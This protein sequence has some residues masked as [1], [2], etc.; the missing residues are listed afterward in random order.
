[1][2]NIEKERRKL[3]RSSVSLTAEV[4][5]RENSESF[6][7]EVT[8]V[9]NV[10]RVG[11]NFN[12]KRE[13][14]VGRLV[15]LSINMPEMFRRYDYGK[16]LYRVWGLVQH[17]RPISEADFDGYQI[18]VAFVGKLAPESYPEDPMKSYRVTGIDSD[19]F[20][21][22]G[23][24]KT[25]FVTREYLRFPCSLK[26]RIAQ[27]DPDGMGSQVEEKAIM[28]NVS[29]AGASVFSRL[30]LNSGDSVMFVCDEP[31][32]SSIAVVRNRQYREGDRSTLH[33]QFTENFPVKDLN[34]SFESA[35]AV[36]FDD[37]TAEADEIKEEK[38]SEAREPD[39]LDALEKPVRIE[40]DSDDEILEINGS[41][42]EG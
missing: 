35:E 33:L 3:S 23:E 38:E 13:C 31:G 7:K 12:L 25:P 28:E 19:G 11:A 15:L 29:I 39:N 1:M 9:Q 42:D 6:W 16:K 5:A 20:W 10:S 37:E 24:A 2:S 18:G 22:I 21:N 41:P 4:K 36:V 40:D 14:K 8:D 34:H 26:V 32:F 30:E 27:I 17:C